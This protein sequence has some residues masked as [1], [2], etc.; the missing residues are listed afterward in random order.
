MPFLALVLITIGPSFLVW[1][2]MLGSPSDGQ[3]VL[4]YILSVPSG[5]ILFLG[6]TLFFALSRRYPTAANWSL[7]S[8]GA[9]VVLFV[10]LM[11]RSS[12]ASR[13]AR[14][15]EFVSTAASPWCLFPLIFGAL[16]LLSG[17][18]VFKKHFRNGE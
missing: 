16:V 3:S 9:L 1:L 6:G 18:W 13:D 4:A 14:F 10:L 8:S 12:A 2:S 11:A 7:R 17:P 5:I 15:S